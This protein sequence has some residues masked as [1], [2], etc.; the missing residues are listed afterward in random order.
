MKRASPIERRITPRRLPKT[1][2]VIVCEGKVTEPKYFNDFLALQNSPL[3]SVKAIGGCGVPVS[4]VERAVQEKKS[5]DDIARKTR[6]SFDADFQV[7]AVF[8][9]D[10]H[11]K[12]QVPDAFALAERN[13]IKIA[14]SNPCFEVWGLMHFECWA[15][16]GHHHETQRALKG[17]LAGYCHEQNPVIDVAAL[18]TRYV[19]AV[20]NAI[21]A[22][23][24]REEEGSSCHGDPSTNVHLLTE[25]IRLNGRL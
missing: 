2:L 12:P 21:R 20:A 24:R 22:A 13:G 19:Q 1:R 3:V 14:Y 18:Q 5:L 6:D 9:R 10:E 25:K 11:P 8:D 15:K 16:P 17:R 7:W 23:V 4:V